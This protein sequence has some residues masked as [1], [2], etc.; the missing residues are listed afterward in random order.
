M[1]PERG[2]IDI[3]NCSYY[4]DVLVVKVHPKIL[5]KQNLPEMKAGTDLWEE[6][7]QSIRDFDAHLHRNGTRI[8]KFFLHVSKEEQSKRL[9][10]RIDIPD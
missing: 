9:L 7:Y 2:E 4:E 6:S 8:I 1:L 5:D 10:E 3:F